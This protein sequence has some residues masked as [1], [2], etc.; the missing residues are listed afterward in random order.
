VNFTCDMIET[1]IRFVCTYRAVYIL[2][3]IALVFELIT[4]II[5]NTIIK[6]YKKKLK[7]LPATSS[8]ESKSSRQTWQIPDSK[9]TTVYKCTTGW[10][11]W[12]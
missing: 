3:C 5:I 8:Q 1:V 6:Y 2:L 7:L 9:C 10:Q 12:W 4:I 11:I